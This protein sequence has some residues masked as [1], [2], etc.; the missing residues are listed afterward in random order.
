[1]EDAELVKMLAVVA[2]EIKTLNKRLS[3]LTAAVN[4]LGSKQGAS[5][6]PK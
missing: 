4:Y 6:P 5:P 1:M 3:D 2:S